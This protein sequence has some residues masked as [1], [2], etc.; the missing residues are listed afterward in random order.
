M[1]R[2]N[3]TREDIVTSLTAHHGDMD[4]ALMELNKSQLKPFLMRIWGP[5]AGI[6]N[7][8]A[9]SPPMIVNNLAT[10]EANM[11]NKLALG[12]FNERT[13]EPGRASI[14]KNVESSKL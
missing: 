7:D 1:S 13:E 12:N 9:N 2:G 10:D 6:E 5:P 8:S 3:F 4:A 14:Q 11:L